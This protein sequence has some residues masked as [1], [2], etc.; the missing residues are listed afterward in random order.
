MNA[1][2]LV[3]TALLAG[4]PGFAL[5]QTPSSLDQA[6]NLYYA[7]AFEQALARVDDLAGRGDAVAPEVEELRAVC[8][9]ALGRRQ[10]AYHSVSALVEAHPER[11]F[12]SVDL[13]PAVRDVL[14]SIREQAFVD[15]MRRR[16]ASAK[17]AFQSGDLDLAGR[18]FEAVRSAFARLSAARASEVADLVSLSSDFLGLI[19]SARQQVPDRARLYSDADPGIVLPAVLEQTVP[20]PPNDRGIDFSGTVLL[21]IHIGRSGA[22][23][24]TYL[25]QG[26]HLVYDSMIL[27]A[28]R[29]WRY[30]PAM[31]G[32]Q[33]VR[34]RKLLR[35]DVR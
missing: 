7:A 15:L 4:V 14:E 11:A 30:R 2:S 8:L 16:Y 3:L 22:V 33:P 20:L 32:D 19:D 1:L 35:I 26:I 21:E 25:Q 17:T 24:V 13:A 28:A 23:E 18:E 29:N 9:L 12:D 34:F 5:G 27:A 31:L 10:E 6:R